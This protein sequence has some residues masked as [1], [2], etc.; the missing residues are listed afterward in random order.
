MIDANR[1]TKS[2]QLVLTTVFPPKKT[3]KVQK[4]QLAQIK[5]CNK[6]NYI[7]V[8]PKDLHTFFSANADTFE[9]NKAITIFIPDV[10]SLTAPFL[11]F[12]LK[13]NGFSGCR[14]EV[15]HGGLIVHAAR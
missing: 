2:M 11:L 3:G 9:A 5:L 13:R 15:A 6:Y 4:M 14:A 1:L 7:T 12:Y 10:L 8:Y